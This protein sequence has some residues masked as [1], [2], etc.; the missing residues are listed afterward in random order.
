MT[1]DK[2]LLDCMRYI[3]YSNAKRYL[4]FDI[5]ESCVPQFCYY[6][7]RYLLNHIGKGFRSLEFLHSLGE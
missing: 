3:S 7:E 2:P 6:C 4:S 5:P 1:L